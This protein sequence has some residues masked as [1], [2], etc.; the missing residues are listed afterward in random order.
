MERR[1]RDDFKETVLDMQKYVEQVRQLKKDYLQIYGRGDKKMRMT[2]KDLL[3]I[4][5]KAV[6]YLLC[7]DSKESEELIKMAKQVLGEQTWKTLASQALAD[8]LSG[9]EAELFD[10]QQLIEVAGQKRFDERGRSYL[11]FLAGNQAIMNYNFEDVWRLVQCLLSSQAAIDLRDKDSST[12][13][14]EAMRNHNSIMVAAL[15]AHGADFLMSALDLIFRKDA[16]TLDTFFQCKVSSFKRMYTPIM[17]SVPLGGQF[18]SRDS[19]LYDAVVTRHLER[20]CRQIKLGAKCTYKDSVDG[21]AFIR[22]VVQKMPKGLRPLLEA[23][24]DV[25]AKEKGGIT[26]LHWGVHSRCLETVQTLLDLRA[27]S[28]GATT[29]TKGTISKYSPCWKST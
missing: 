29:A 15:L 25:N 22:C 19:R 2:R 27:D 6:H 14:D 8:E 10:V 3:W 21:T 5:P 26:A 17:W 28:G 16:R 12:P 9:P 1:K 7:V 18:R 4:T 11:H 13:L 23:A 24:A 20:V